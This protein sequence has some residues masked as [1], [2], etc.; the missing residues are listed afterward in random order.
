M[1]HRQL[2]PA[3]VA[4]D[5][6]VLCAVVGEHPLHILLLGAEDEVEQED[7]NPQN[8]LQQIADQVA[9][10]HLLKQSAQEGGQENEQAHGKADA[11]HHGQ[12]DEDL[13]KLFA[14][15]FFLQ[16]DLE[17][18]GLGGRFL[19]VLGIE[20]GGEHQSLDPLDH[21]V[22]E[23]HSPS[24]QGDAQDGVAFF[25]Q[26][27]LLHFGDQIA[28]RLADDDGLL[29]GTAHQDPLNQRL[30]ADGGAKGSGLGRVIGLLC[31]SARSPYQ[32]L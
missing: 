3:F 21:G 5:G 11:Q 17:F 14:A 20:F 7:D 6:F 24:D 15:Q 25:D 9:G 32:S 29:F 4:E 23:I 22:Q 28:V 26:V 10:D 1:V 31:H 8:A 18:G 19:F 13:H 2:Q 12:G 30:S 16:P 27:E